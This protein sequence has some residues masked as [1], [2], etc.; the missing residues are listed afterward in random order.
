MPLKPAL[1]VN[2]QIALLQQRGMIFADTSVVNFF[3][4]SNNYY[5]L[6]IYFH[7]FMDCPD[8]F[9]SGTQFEHI[10]EIYKNDQWLRN[11][12]LTV[13]EPIEIK[14]KTQIAYYL[15]LTYGPNC[16]YRADIYKQEDICGILLENFEKEINR[17]KEDP[18]VYHH[19]VNYEGNFPIWVIVEFLSFNTISKFFSK[20]QEKDKKCIATAAYNL[21]EYFLG[22]WLHV[23]SVLRNICAHY[24]YL[25]LR[26]Y[27]VR[28][29]LSQSFRWDQ[30]KN[31]RLFAMF[32]V[33]RRLSESAKW[34]TF[35]QEVGNKE[36]VTPSFL[37][38]DYGFP[39]DWQR[40]LISARMG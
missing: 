5:R 21:N 6:N 18:V 36:Q 17:N 30:N 33:I 31:T 24:G 27:S 26:T 38:R 20:L 2:D 34:Q 8:H 25:Y 37:L 16:F 23:L 7:K 29:K 3:L 28:P 13:L 15:G 35:I 39:R 19:N 22:Q 4:L 32:L 40:F 10:I 9:R 11:K 14:I 1:S 12:I